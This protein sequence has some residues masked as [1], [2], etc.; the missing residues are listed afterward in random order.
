[1]HDTTE[2]GSESEFIASS[3]IGKC[4]IQQSQGPS[5]TLL[6]QWFINVN[7]EDLINIGLIAFVCW[8]KHI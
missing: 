4:M 3:L 8:Y 2:S 7:G 1:M 5:P 6:V